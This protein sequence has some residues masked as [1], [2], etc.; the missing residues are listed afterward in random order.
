MQDDRAKDILMDAQQSNA[1]NRQNAGRLLLVVSLQQCV[2]P[3]LLD[4]A[5]QES[6]CG[7]FAAK[8]PLRPFL[9]NFS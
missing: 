8:F 2:A 4:E 5:T 6:A 9:D 1:A 7:K 3:A